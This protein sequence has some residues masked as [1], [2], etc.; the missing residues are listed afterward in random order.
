MAARAKR[1]RPRPRLRV[2]P[3]G[4]NDKAGNRY[5]D[6]K[7]KTYKNKIHGKPPRGCSLPICPYHQAMHPCQSSPPPAGIGLSSHAGRAR[8]RGMNVRP[9][10][11][12][13]GS[14]GGSVSQRQ[15]YIPAAE[16]GVGPRVTTAIPALGIRSDPTGSIPSPIYREFPDPSDVCIAWHLNMVVANCCEAGRGPV[17]HQESWRML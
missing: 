4:L 9:V 11:A 3:K 16:S 5:N 1:P 7:K 8:I 12:G 6:D 10:P 13:W 15:E 2:N 17:V 14:A